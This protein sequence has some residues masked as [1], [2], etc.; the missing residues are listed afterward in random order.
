MTKQ[1]VHLD[2][3]PATARAET[4]SCASRSH[5]GPQLLPDRQRASTLAEFPD[6]EDWPATQVSFKVKIASAALRRRPS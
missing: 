2:R 5:V 3:L 6:W 1:R 4:A